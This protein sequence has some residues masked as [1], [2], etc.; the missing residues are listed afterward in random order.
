MLQFVYA[1]NV[2]GQFYLFILKI[3]KLLAKK[4]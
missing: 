2:C 4:P 3:M 1:L